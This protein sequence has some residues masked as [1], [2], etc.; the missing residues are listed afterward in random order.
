MK[1]TNWLRFFMTLSLILIC[2]TFNFAQDWPQW[3][4]SNRDGKVTGFTAPQNWPET[5]TQVWSVSVGLANSTPALVGDKLYV[6][7][8]QG[9]EEITRCLDAASGKELWQDK[10]EA[11]TVTGPATG[12]PGPRSS[13]TAAEGKVLTLGVG[14]ILSCFDAASGKR[15]WRKDEFPGKWP[16]FFSGMSPMIVDGMAIAHVGN[17]E[18]GAVFAYDLNTGEQKW[19]WEGDGPAYASP[20]LMTVGDTKQLVVQTAQNILGLATAD[21]KLLWKV[22]TTPEF[23][24][25]N[26]ATPMIDGQT[27]I[28]TGQ[29]SGTRALKVEKQGDNFI[30]IELWHN[31][32]VGTGF[33]TPILKEGMLYG[34]TNE[35]NLYCMNEQTGEMTWMEK[36]RFQRGFGAIVD[37]GSVLMV[38]PITSE[39]VV[40]EP[41]SEKYTELA[42][43]KVAE[44]ATYAHPVISGNHIFIKDEETLKLYTIQ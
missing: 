20:V 43:I 29:G 37:A 40:F 13:V 18:S 19:K 11:V 17:T 12:H 6:F 32:D 38:L 26:S 8:R 36:T 35:G 41:N 44:T 21:G 10:Y 1:H 23:R 5:P 2:I 24:F 7:T 4:G 9:E 33:N 34:I 22:E 27:V 30:T 42:R 15:L 14:N 3:R 39:L 28:Y 25:F 31:P 16:E